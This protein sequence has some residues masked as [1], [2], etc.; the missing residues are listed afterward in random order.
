MMAVDFSP[1]PRPVTG[2]PRLLFEF[3]WRTLI[4][5]CEPAGC[6]DVAPNGQRFYV[7]KGLPYP[8]RPVVTHVNLILNW[9]DELK[10]KVPV[11]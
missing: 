10:E 8:P 3:D 9:F 5:T 1:G 7:V 4:F 2:P 11:K 6:Y